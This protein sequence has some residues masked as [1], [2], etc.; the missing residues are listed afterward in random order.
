MEH[1][2][3]RIPAD[4]MLTSWLFTQRA[5]KELNS[6]LPR[7]NPE[8]SRVE[9]LQGHQDFKSSTL[10]HWAGARHPL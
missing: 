7:T 10:N 3:L 1:E 2:L 8:N 9:H 4:G 5:A 6:G